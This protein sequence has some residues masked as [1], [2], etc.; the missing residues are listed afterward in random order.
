MFGNMLL[1]L[2]TCPL[3]P[4]LK[5]SCTAGVGEDGVIRLVAGGVVVGVGRFVGV[6]IRVGATS[7]EELDGEESAC[8]RAVV[9]GAETV[10]TC[11]GTRGLKAKLKLASMSTP[12]V[13]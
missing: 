6:E 4:P 5:A 1:A 11:S 10:A 9:V 12:I 13:P 2:V 8:W 3:T 7:G